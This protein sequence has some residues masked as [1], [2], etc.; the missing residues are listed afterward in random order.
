MSTPTL[1][2]TVTVNGQNFTREVE[3][4]HLLADFLRHQRQSRLQCSHPLFHTRIRGLT[5]RVLNKDTLSSTIR[6][7]TDMSVERFNHRK[8]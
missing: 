4:R 5:A 2:I 3:P 6:P 8:G 7:D 1:K